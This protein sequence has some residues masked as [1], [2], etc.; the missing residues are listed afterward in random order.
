[1]TEYD[2]VYYPV[3]VESALAELETEIAERGETAFA[4]QRR[5]KWQAVQADYENGYHQVFFVT[6][7]LKNPQPGEPEFEFSDIGDGDRYDRSEYV[8]ACGLQFQWVFGFDAPL[9]QGWENLPGHR[10]PDGTPAEVVR[11]RFEG[12]ESVSGQAEADEPV[13][14]APTQTAKFHPNAHRIQ[15]LAF[16]PRRFLAELLERDESGQG[17]AAEDLEEAAVLIKM[18]R[19]QELRAHAYLG[20][21]ACS[22]FAIAEL[23]EDGS[24]PGELKT[25]SQGTHIDPVNKVIGVKVFVVASL[26]LPFSA[27]ELPPAAA[28]EPTELR[29]FCQ[30]C[31]FLPDPAVRDEDDTDW[32]PIEHGGHTWP[33]NDWAEA[34]LPQL[35]HQNNENQTDST[36]N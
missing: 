11:F 24:A 18:V 8:C 32:M 25:L 6:R 12:K 13:E 34:G 17:I 2:P 16:N 1:M 22:C 26:P 5:S 7:W 20:W 23:D 19:L 28:T 9:D 27:D 4:L 31:G 36:D 3:S 30:E 21:G 33:L 15:R 29:W 14:D 35:D 10:N